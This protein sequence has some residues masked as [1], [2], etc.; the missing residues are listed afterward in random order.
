M[1]LFRQ[2]FA[3]FRIYTC[4]MGMKYNY[5]FF[6]VSARSPTTTCACI[7]LPPKLNMVASIRNVITKLRYVIKGKAFGERR[8]QL[9]IVKELKKGTI[10]MR[11]PKHR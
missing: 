10:K 1:I 5:R 4:A 11:V 2:W 7:T 8:P 6:L 9:K 3:F